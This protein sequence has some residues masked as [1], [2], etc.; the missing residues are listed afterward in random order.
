MSDPEWSLD[1][2]LAQDTVALGDLPLTRVLVSRDANYPWLILVPRRDGAVE[3]IDLSET[4]Q[5][6]L[7]T[8]MSHTARVLKAVTRCDKLNIAA[9]GNA[10][11][12]LHVHVIARSPGDA[13]GTRPV[14]NAVP[15]RRYDEAE[16][17]RFLAAL[18][19]GFGVSRGV[20]RHIAP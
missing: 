11:R 13:A 15:A 10:V 3:I 4:D 8:E 16:L 5:A 6:I 18:R 12:Q 7:M 14:W 17:A 2:R 20:L 19:A 1:P 9:L